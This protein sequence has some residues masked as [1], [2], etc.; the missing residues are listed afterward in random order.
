MITG[1][2]QGQP[3]RNGPSIRAIHT[4]LPNVELLVLAADTLLALFGYSTDRPQF[5]FD[6]VF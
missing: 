3:R 1:K 5:Y 2:F 6:T 4:A